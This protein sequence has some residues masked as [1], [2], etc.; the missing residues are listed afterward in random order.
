MKLKKLDV[1]EALKTITAP[2]AAENLVD[3]K[4]VTNIMIFGDQIDIDVLLSNPTLQARK[5]LEVTI[6]KTI[7]EQVYEKAKINKFCRGMFS[8]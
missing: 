4:A 2:G 5:K 6:L 7:H 8:I 1:V 3:S